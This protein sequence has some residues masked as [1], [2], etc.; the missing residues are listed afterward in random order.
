MTA[1]IPGRNSFCPCGSGKRYKKCCGQPGGKPQL[2]P[3]AVN[4]AVAYAGEVGQQRGAFCESYTRYKQGEMARLVAQLKSDIEAKGK[5]ISCGR[6][7]THCCK[8]YVF[9][10]LQEA[11][12]IAYYLYTH[13]DALRHFLKSYADWKARINPI[14]QNLERLE[15][16]QEKILFGRESVKEREVFYA[17]LSVYAGLNTPCPF[18]E[19]G[20]C[21]IYEVRPYTCACVVSSSPPEWCDRN[22]PY[23]GKTSIYKAQPNRFA[24]PP[25]LGLTSSI[26][27]ACLPEL[28]H[29]ILAYGYAFLSSFEGL[30]KLKPRAAADPEV[31]AVLRDMGAL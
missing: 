10:T 18:L 27:F 4:R 19:D 28:V 17:D 9:A 26:I 1:A 24:E 15:K 2:D 13:D 7:C 12:A 14:A 31:R 29:H 11:D 21:T 25:Y 20:A 16:L 22:N 8:V 23:R 30:E 6:G 5:T 3:I